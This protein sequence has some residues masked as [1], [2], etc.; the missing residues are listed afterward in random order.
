MHK[1]LIASLLLILSLRADIVMKQS[2]PKDDLVTIPEHPIHHPERPLHRPPYY[3]PEYV[4]TGI[5]IETQ[6]DCTQYIDL[7]REKDAYIESLLSELAVLRE[8]EQRRLSEKLRKE[9]E[10][11]LKKFK[12]HKRSINTRNSII[13]KEKADI[14]DKQHTKEHP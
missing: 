5:I 10:A 14:I 7:L 4:P 6:S 9:H 3:P 13:I 2:K 8:K 12:E 1:A 11:E